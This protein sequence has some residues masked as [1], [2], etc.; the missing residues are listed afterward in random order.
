MPK[1]QTKPQTQ[2][3]T[4]AS[5]SVE[6]DS[7]EATQGWTVSD[8]ESLYRASRWGQGYFSIAENGTLHARPRGEGGPSFDLHE[9]VEGLA[10]RGINTPVL[11]RFSDILNHR[12]GSIR[13][14]FSRA[15]EENNYKGDYLAAYPI[16]VN[17]Q[18][19]IVEEVASFGHSLGFGLEVGS[20]PELLAV[21]A[22]TVKTP[23]Q[24]VI[25]NGFK[26]AQYIEAV[27]LAHKLGRKIIPVVENIKE[28]RLI[29]NFAE[30]HGVRP[31]I[32]VR[33][34]LSATGSGRWGTS[35]G[36]KSKFGLTIAELLQAVGT[37]KRHDMLDCLDLLHCHS[38]SQHQDIGTIK[39]AITELVHVFVQLRE[40]GAKLSYLDIGGGLGVDYQGSVSDR[41]SSMNYT[42]E[43][44]ASD[45]VYRIG[46]VCDANETSH[47]TIVTECGRAM[48]AY[49]SV[50]IFNILGST[51]PRDLVDDRI[52]ARPPH[53]DD[54]QPLRD[55]FSSLQSLNEPKPR[56]VEIYHDTTRAREEALSLFTLGY[57]SL[58][59][60]AEC[61]RLFWTI[62][63]RLQQE[64]RHL[65]QVPDPLAD[66]DDLMSE[67]YFAN[68]SLFQS[69]PDTWAIDQL[70]PIMPIHRLGEEPGTRAVL[71]DITCDS[72][73]KVDLFISEQGE[74]EQTLPVHDLRLGEP[75]YM[76][77]FLVGAYQ[78]TLGDLHN[79]FG[80]PH[81]VHIELDGDDW[82]IAEIVKGDSISEVLS[83][84]QF[85]PDKLARA[86]EKEC[87]RAV[88]RKDMSIRESR[89]LTQFYASGLS[90]YTYLNVENHLT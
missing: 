22:L 80:D 43:E 37:L 18:H 62:C 14:A 53:P 54:P 90:G 88:K 24:L 60:R 23:D 48:V 87:E 82:A 69:L 31:R 56:L 41:A 19:Q 4:A 6:A 17:Q 30:K 78:E 77:A 15:I 44:Y 83:Y 9:I 50:L 73:G 11:L 29:I 72:D 34:K 75:Y 74:P 25:C 20:K 5:R 68:F 57:L 10:E 45:V 61:E 55:L 86:L 13:G 26:D 51:G 46:S 59:H 79:L 33:V 89:I 36:I 1:A 65:E 7:P 64:C 39:R 52:T 21:M 38:G 8:A 81:A 49:S 42:L 85:E 32:G 2:P 58:E 67:T 35:V 71:A 70:F 66:I 84:V 47:P 63:S 16:K 28:L 40:I 27:I 3:K 76:G 12:L